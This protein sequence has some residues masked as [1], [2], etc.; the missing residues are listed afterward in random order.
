MMNNEVLRLACR[1]LRECVLRHVFPVSPSRTAQRVL[2]TAPRVLSSAAPRSKATLC[3]ASSAF[4]L[5]TVSCHRHTRDST[6]AFPRLFH[7]PSSR[8][9]SRLPSMSSS[10]LTAPRLAASTRTLL[11]RAALPRVLAAPPG[12]R[13]ASTTAATADDA[14]ASG[15]TCCCGAPAQTTSAC[16]DASVAVPFSTASGRPRV[17]RSSSSSSGAFP[18]STSQRRGFHASARAFLAAKED[19]YTTLGVSKTASKDEIK[20]AYYKLAKKYHPDTNKDDPK[21]AEKFTA[22]QHAY[23]VLSDDGKRSTYDQFGE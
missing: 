11:G 10:L 8:W 23:E 21:A 17:P 6:C 20:K 9:C 18:S 4:G 5:V 16:A 14:P 13:W 1:R 15:C 7:T 22:V 19:F 2:P 12:Q 3:P